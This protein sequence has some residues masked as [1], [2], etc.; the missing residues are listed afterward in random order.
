MIEVMT[1]KLYITR[2]EDRDVVVTILAK[3]GY[4]VRQGKEKDKSGKR[5]VSFVECWKGE[6]DGG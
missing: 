5:N 4:T 2:P 3:N 1:T 6:K